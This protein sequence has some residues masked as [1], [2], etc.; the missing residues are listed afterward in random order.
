MSENLKIDWIRTVSHIHLRYYVLG[1]GGFDKMMLDRWGVKII[2]NNNSMFEEITRI[3][4][5]EQISTLLILNY[6]SA[7]S[8]TTVLNDE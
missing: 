5:D 8:Y 2:R 3:E 6:P 7:I 1:T 4:V